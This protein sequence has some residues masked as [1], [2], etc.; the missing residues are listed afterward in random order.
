MVR[1]QVC[2]KRMR[3]GCL[4]MPDLESHWLPERLTYLGLSFSGDVVWRRKVRK[5]FHLGP[6]TFHGLGKNYIGNWLWTLLRTLS[7]SSTAGR[8]RKSAPIGNGRP[9]RVSWKIQSSCSPGDLHRTPCLFLASASE[10]TWQTYPIVLDVA[11]AWKKRLSP[12]ST[13]AIEFARCGTTSGSGRLAS[14]P[15]SSLVTS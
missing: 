11:V 14:N 10:R 5:I 2:I 4:G 8:R 1:R 15:S 13:T 6:V 7:M 3:N 9:V 12:T